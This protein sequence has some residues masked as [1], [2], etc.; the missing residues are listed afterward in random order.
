MKR[1]IR[2]AM[3]DPSYTEA[4][5]TLDKYD[6]AQIDIVNKCLDDEAELMS[7]YYADEGNFEDIPLGEQ[8]SEIRRD[9]SSEAYEDD[10]LD[11]D[12]WDELYTAI[13]VIRGE[14]ANAYS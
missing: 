8:L 13:S 11:I 12:Q 14:Y 2:A 5:K 10:L 7:R 6:K 9:W 3:F 4:Q 1:L